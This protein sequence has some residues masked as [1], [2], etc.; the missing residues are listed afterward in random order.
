MSIYDQNLK[1]YPREVIVSLRAKKDKDFDYDKVGEVNEYLKKYKIF[2]KYIDDDK[3]SISIDYDADRA[4]E[5]EVEDLDYYL[6]KDLGVDA[7]V[8]GNDEI[9]MFNIRM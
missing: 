3:K 9:L 8:S 6:R 2:A 4:F 1:N 5:P 7:E